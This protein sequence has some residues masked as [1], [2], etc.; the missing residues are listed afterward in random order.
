MKKMP[1][2]KVVTTFAI[3]VALLMQ[4]PYHEAEKDG[5][6]HL[7]Q[8]H[9]LPSLGRRLAGFDSAGGLAASAEKRYSS[10]IV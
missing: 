4:C 6:H 8:A 9:V 10:A 3:A 2:I 7:S 1:S 5:Q